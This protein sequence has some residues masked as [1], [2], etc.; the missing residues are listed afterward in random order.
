[1]TKNGKEVF[2]VLDFDSPN[3][4][5]ADN[6]AYLK[7]VGRI[8]LSGVQPKASYAASLALPMGMLSR[9]GTLIFKTESTF[10]LSAFVVFFADSLCCAIRLT[11]NP[12]ANVIRTICILFIFSLLGA[13][14]AFISKNTKFS[15]DYF[16]DMLFFQFHQ[17]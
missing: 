15:S 13:K 1:M 2:P 7:N 6:E 3:N 4:D 12:I 10:V 8:S 16:A 14:L 11:L 17:G 9:G 5:S